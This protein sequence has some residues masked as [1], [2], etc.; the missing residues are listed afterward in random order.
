MSTYR[1]VEVVMGLGV[2]VEGFLRGKGCQAV[3]EA[4]LTYRIFLNS[5]SYH[6][7]LASLRIKAINKG[8]LFLRIL[9]CHSVTKNKIN[10]FF[11]HVN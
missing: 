11:Y 2:T 9:Y 6:G 4:H 8:K 3:G 10:Y 5:V 7:Y 1:E